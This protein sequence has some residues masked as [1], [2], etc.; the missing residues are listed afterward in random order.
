MG[1]SL[2][3]IDGRILSHP[4]ASKALN[5]KWSWMVYWVVGRQFACDL[6]ASLD[7]KPPCA[8]RHLISLKCEPDRIL[9]LRTERPDAVL[10]GCYSDG[11]TWISVDLGS[12]LPEELVL[13]LCDMSYELVFAKLS[14]RVQREIAGEVRYTADVAE[15]W[16]PSEDR[17]RSHNQLQVD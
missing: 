2:K 6:T 14:N 4:G 12:N 8:G 15:A 1:V 17:H 5:E 11:R 9:E 16:F 10:P 7:A 13:D 3:P